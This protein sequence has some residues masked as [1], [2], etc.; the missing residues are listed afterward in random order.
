M[1]CAVA[2]GLSKGGLVMVG[3]ISVPLLS[4]VMSPVQAA[5][6]LLPV[7][8]VS[9]MGGLV[10]YRKAWDRRV[11]LS[12][13]PGA[14][15]GIVAGWATAHLVSDRVVGLIVGVIGAVY[16]IR[17]LWRPARAGRGQPGTLRGSFWGLLA[18]YTS[19]VSHNGAA[20]Y[21]VYVQPLG[22]SAIAYA[23]TTTVFFAIVNLI[24]L[25]PYAALGQFNAANL[26]V[27]AILC[28]PAIV[29]VWLGV[30]LV[31]IMP[32]AIFYRFITWAL[33]LVSLW[34]IWAGLA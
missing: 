15:V 19:F 7:Y 13:L 14:V 32:A 28:L 1:I 4:L 9:D 6:L 24:K 31:R 11:L 26:A 25:I 10:V 21:Q 12:L 18:G 34:L 27:A 16:A 5:A 8:I 30:R 2:V 22:L 23:G 29:S 3:T 17:A 20:P 33:L